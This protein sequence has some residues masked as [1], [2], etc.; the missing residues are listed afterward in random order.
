MAS[1]LQFKINQIQEESDSWKRFL[2]FMGEEN[3]YLKNR[4]S[5]AAKS[6]SEKDSLINLENFLDR[7]VHHDEAIRLMK[8]DLS[9]F[10]KLIVRE[11]Y[12]DGHVSKKLEQELRH[13]RVNVKK[14]AEHFEQLK[15]E[16]NSYLQE[17]TL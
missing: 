9:E 16:F 15:A 8:Q 14:L 13:N 3:I 2:A 4:L 10:D 17:N 5:L 12:E 1:M 7:S 6:G 11:T